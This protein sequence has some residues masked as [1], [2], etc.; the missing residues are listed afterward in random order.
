MI[1]TDVVVIGSGA[2][3]LAAAL[4]AE[5]QGAK[6][7]ILER[8]EHLGGILPQ[9][10]HDGFGNFVFGKMLTG[11][12]YAQIFIDRVASS[13]ITTLCNTMVLDISIDKR[14]TAVNEQYGLFEIQAK[15]V[16]LAMGCREKTRNQILLP[17]TRPAGIYTAGMVQRFINVEGVMPGKKIVILGSGD[18]GLIMAR[19]LTLEGAVVE[20]VFEMMD[21]PNG[22]LRNLV[23]CLYDYEIPL[24]LSQTVIDIHGRKR[25]EGV[26][27]AKVDSTFKSI[28]G[29]ERF[30]ACDCLVLAVG[31]IP[32]NELSKKI[33]DSDKTLL[34]EMHSF[35]QQVENIIRDVK[36]I[37]RGLDSRVV[38]QL[39]LVQ[40][41]RWQAKE[42]EKRTNL[43]IKLKIDIDEQKV[44][45]NIAVSIFRIFQEAL[46]NIIRHAGATK[47]D[48]VLKT[49]HEKIIFIIK[50]NGQGIPSAKI[51]DPRSMGIAGIKERVFALAGEIKII[52]RWGRY[53]AF[54]IKIPLPSEK[55][56][57]L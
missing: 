6:V 57:K 46:T 55:G 19:R 1:E 25:L 12:E 35:S 52:S 37:A 7:M 39:N 56:E 28:P 8:S 42:I 15:A 17:G 3:G 2:A 4:S 49:K 45:K 50:D 30:I 27:V 26:T 40:T 31:L 43:H 41:M 21:H 16:V 29:T 23:Q 32:E 5:Q 13:S 51:V 36:Y 20:G 24:F 11:P 22:L 44:N 14:V 34:K 10:I 54:V 48:V 53:T 18:V 9:C 38:N 47:V 33:G